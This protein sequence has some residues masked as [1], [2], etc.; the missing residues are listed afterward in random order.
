MEIKYIRM[1]IDV[2]RN[3]KQKKNSNSP[4]LLRTHRQQAGGGGSKPVTKNWNK[5]SSKKKKNWNKLNN[6]GWKKQ[7]KEN[8]KNQWMIY[9][10]NTTYLAT[11]QMWCN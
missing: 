10:R 5:L 11:S 1:K 8:V 7:Q 6:N 3:G 2:K 9:D 4:Y